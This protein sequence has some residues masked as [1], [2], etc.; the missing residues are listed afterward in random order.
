MTSY[1]VVRP[2]SNYAPGQILTGK[3]FVSERRAKQLVDQRYIV[4]IGDKALKPRPGKEDK[5]AEQ[6]H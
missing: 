6:T 4:A 5:D 2:F 1:Q 3:D